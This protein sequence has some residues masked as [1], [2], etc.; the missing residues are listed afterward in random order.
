MYRIPLMALA[1]TCGMSVMVA[2]ADTIKP[3]K[4][5]KP[6][7]AG[8]IFLRKDAVKEIHDGNATT[9]V[10]TFTSQD[11]AFQTGIFKSGP[12]H[13]VTKGP[14][15]YPDNEFMY[16]ISGSV[17]LTSSDGSVMVVHAG[18]GVTLPRGWTGIFD[19]QGYTKMYVTYNPDD[20]K[21]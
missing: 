7:I 4:D 20:I 12:F 15:G 3:M 9:D 10:V 1:L 11:S 13:E 6:D 19:T 5:S 21:K 2:Q 17:T 8:A 16:F 14:Q 18:E